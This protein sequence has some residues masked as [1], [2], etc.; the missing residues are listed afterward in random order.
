MSFITNDEKCVYKQAFREKTGN[1]MFNN[2]K[3]KADLLK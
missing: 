2:A 3:N 1:T